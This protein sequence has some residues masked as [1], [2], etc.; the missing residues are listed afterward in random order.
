MKGFLSILLLS[1]TF[2]GCKNDNKDDNYAYLGGE[3]INPTTNYII[4]EKDGEIIDTIPLDG[5]NRFIHKFEGLIPGFYTFN[6]GGEEQ[7]ALL[8]PKDSLLFRL[9]TLE[10]DESLVFTGLGDKK[11]NYFIN[12][13]IE[14]ELREKY[15]FKICQLAPKTYQKH[16]DSLNSI[17]LIAFNKFKEKYETT[18]LFNTIAEANI[19]FAHYSNKEIYPFIHYGQNKIEILN[20][21]PKDFYAYRKNIDYN[22]AFFSDNS[23]YIHFL[24]RNLSNISLTIHDEHAEEKKFNHRSLCYN[25]DRLQLID[26]LVTNTTIKDALLYHFTIKYLSKSQDVE[27]SEKLLKSYLNKST[28][29]KG[30]ALMCRLNESIN[31][32]QRGAKLP[33]IAVLNYNNISNNISAVIKQPTVISFWAQS[34]YDHFNH[35]YKKINELKVKYPEVNFIR[36]N[37]DDYEVGKPKKM[38]A[39]HNYSTQNEYTFSNPKQA[40]ETLAIYPLTK[41]FIVDKNN[42]IVSSNSNLFSIKFEEELLG[43]INR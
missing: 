38:L 41:T 34:F 29:E 20:S 2:L 39:N 23:N 30:K 15:I 12:D 43:L 24:R 35:S 22:D 27:N 11:N 42:T 4:L 13:F 36:I 16:I 19:K 17:K 37:I 33:D 9:N 28:N 7:F 5:R 3:I 31:R 26:S 1:L 40:K 32:L 8:E 6:H 21:L 10:F 18:E 25:L 14:N